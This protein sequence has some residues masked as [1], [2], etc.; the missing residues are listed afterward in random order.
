MLIRI[1][2]SL[3]IILIVSGCASLSKSQCQVGDWYSIG[4][5]DGYE[6][7]PAHTQLAEHF[8][9]CSEYG[10]NIDRAP[11]D[12]GH[13]EGL[14]A[15]CTLPRGVSEGIA[16]RNYQGVC[17]GESEIDF[18]EGFIAG[19]ELYKVRQEIGTLERSIEN[20]QTKIDKNGTAHKDN[21][22]LEAEILLYRGQISQLNIRLGQLQ[23]RT[24]NLVSEGS[25]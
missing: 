7:K 6:G 10:I 14:V 8:K 17:T 9:A 24:R 25:F 18:Q 16:G 5:S 22:R 20:T 2:L 12:Q 13:L 11:Y 4:K 23:E 3:V 19:N 1:F 15:Y 21:H